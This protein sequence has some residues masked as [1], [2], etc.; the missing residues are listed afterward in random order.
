VNLDNY[1]SKDRVN[2]IVQERAKDAAAK[3]YERARQEFESKQQPSQSV[4]QAQTQNFGGMPQMSEEQ[5]R[6]IAEEVYQRNSQEAQRSYQEQSHRERMQNLANDFLGKIKSAD[7]D[8]MKRQDEI[9][10]LHSLVPFINEV[11][12]VAGVTAHLLDNG[13][14][15]ASL[16]TLM[17]DA[18][19]RLRREVRRL[20]DSIKQN[21]VAK[22]NY[23]DVN[24]PLSQFS[25][26]HSNVDSG[27]TGNIESLKQ[28]DWLRG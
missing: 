9:A 8:L 12:E 14:H 7:P 6:K 25:P 11:D 1:V 10:D 17:K 28:Q 18:P 19:E 20:S 27:S 2:E 5:Y 26:S 23:P 21:R 15:F 3:A 24:A 22:E 16:L 4:Q 13:A